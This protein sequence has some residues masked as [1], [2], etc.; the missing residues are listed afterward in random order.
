M[1]IRHRAGGYQVRLMIDGRQYAATLPTREEARDW[2][3]LVRAR[4]VTGM[5]PRRT[6]VRDYAAHWILGYDTAPTNTR[7]FHEVNLAH[8]VEAL[9]S[10]RVSEV[11]PS[12][13]TRLINQL[14]TRRS[15]A[16]ADRVYRTTSALFSSAA[17]DGLCP[18]GSPVRSKKHRP[19]RQ[20]D[21][22]PVL[23][24]HHARQVLAALT[25][26]QRDTALVQ[27]SLG[28][29]F[30]EIAGLT[31]HD[32]D[33]A[34]GVL[35]IRRRYSA[36]SNTIRSTKN[37]RRRT[38]ELPRL[39]TP[40]LERRIAAV[41]SQ[42]DPDGPWLAAHLAD[43]RGLPLRGIHPGTEPGGDLAP[44][45][46]PARRSRCPTLQAATQSV[47]NLSTAA[48]QPTPPPTQQRRSPVN[49]GP[50]PAAGMRCSSVTRRMLH[51][52]PGDISSAMDHPSDSGA[53]ATRW[54]V[55]VC[56]CSPV[57]GQAWATARHTHRRR[58]G[59]RSGP[60]RSRR[61]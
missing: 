1:S 45:R 40:T 54:L 34:A 59:R 46:R 23:E 43:P 55:P 28:A 39:L 9:G 5:L 24:R 53:G 13:I 16:L 51:A 11:T 58:A 44:R 35:H 37:H 8:I 56:C 49:H 29:R 57:R 21:H 42:I 38:L 26:W 50:I 33:L 15:A 7:V 60:S 20:R 3:R 30:G 41:A 32:V 31:R 52:G 4:A 14:I 6:T 22:Q 27:L 48:H 10:T 25:G 36:H 12:D 61:P 47:G 17:A 18:N 19:R 2:E